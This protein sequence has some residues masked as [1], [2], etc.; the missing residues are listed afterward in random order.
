MVVIE[1]RALYLLARQ[2]RDIH[3]AAD[4]PTE[5]AHGARRVARLVAC[6]ALPLGVAQRSLIAV[7]TRRG[8]PADQ[9]R[10]IVRARLVCAQN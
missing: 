2:A 3:Y 4:A 1:H 8:I 5:L 9:A 10:R 7:A 6:G